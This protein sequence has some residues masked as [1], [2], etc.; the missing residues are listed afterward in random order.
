MYVCMY[1]CMYVRTG[2]GSQAMTAD[3]IVQQMHREI[4]EMSCSHRLRKCHRQGW[5]LSLADSSLDTGC[6]DAA[7]RIA[8]RKL[9]RRGIWRS[10]SRL[11]FCEASIARRGPAGLIQIFMKGF[12][13][14]STTGVG[15]T[16]KGIPL[17]SLLY[18]II[19]L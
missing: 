5:E 10:L 7:R 8:T 13:R 4:R 3:Q 15:I 2:H 18:A 12:S 9:P 17:S 1:V 16:S 14:G 11:N 6:I 19:I